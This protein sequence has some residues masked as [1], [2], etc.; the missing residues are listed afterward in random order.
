M[1][2]I[3]FETQGIN[4]RPDYPPEPVGVAIKIDDQP[5]YY[6]A[7]GHPTDNN[8]T[9]EEAQAK[10]AAVWHH[11]LLFYNAKFDVDVANVHLGLPI[12]DWMFIH[13]AMFLAFLDNPNAK[14]MGL[15]PIAERVLNLPPDEQDE[16]KSWLLAKQPVPDVKISASASSKYAF[17]RYI[18]EAPGDIV[19]KYACGDV[20]RTYQLY[21]LLMPSIIERGMQAAYDR[22]T[23]LMPILLQ[24]ERQGLRI[25]VD[26]LVKD[27]ALYSVWTF[28]LEEWIK[29]CLDSKDDLNLNSGAQLVNAM[30]VVHK[31]NTALMPVTRTGKVSTAK[32]SLLLGVTD[33]VLLDVLTYR[34]QL[35]TCLNTF[36]LPWLETARK[37]R[38]LIYTS[39]N[40]TKSG[41]L[42]AR[43]GRL[44]SNPNFMNIPKAFVPINSS[45]W[46]ELPPLPDVRS[47]II[48]FVDE[49][50]IDRDYIA[51][52]IRLLAHFENGSLL[53]A[54]QKDVNLD[55]HQHAADLVTKLTGLKITRADAKTIAFAIL[56]GAGNTKLAEQIKCTTEEAR[57]I[58]RVY[59]TA[60]PDVKKMI[61]HLKNRCDDNLPVCTWGGRQYHVEPQVL[62]DGRLRTFEYKMLNTLIQA[63]AADVTKQAII[64]FHKLKEPGWRMILNVHDQLTVSVP[65]ADVSL[66]MA[67]L[68]TAMEDV[69]MDVKML[70]DGRVGEKNWAALT[71][72]PELDKTLAKPVQ[73]ITAW[74]FSR[75]SLYMQC[76]LKFK[77]SAI[78]K[79][80]EPKSMAMLRGSEIHKMAED[81]LLGVIEEL[82][83]ELKRFEAEFAHLRAQERLHVEEN[84][85]F[86]N[87][88]S[89]AD[90]FDMLNCWARIKLDCAYYQ[91]KGVLRVIDWKTGKFRSADTDTY[92]KQLELYAL[93]AMV[94]LPGIKE[95][96]PSL[97]YLDVGITYPQESVSY[98]RMDITRLKT[99]WR[100]RVAPMMGDTEFLPTRNKYCYS[101]FYRKSNAPNGG[102]QC[103]LQN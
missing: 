69:P 89:K 55:L 75:Y 32:K 88:W 65:K 19:A 50:F 52:E 10:L 98:L 9:V 73:R 77:L 16:V 79:I 4:P 39:W 85:A 78:D 56:Y 20:D 36:M 3:D 30:K 68:R 49:V 59:L 43:T 13:D 100:K 93:A 76:P 34:T 101:C 17:G 35:N 6:Y 37:S 96:R 95:V 60:L 8:C 91:A 66:A 38:G 87:Q 99:L 48:P 31:V 71:A 92:T 23:K 28:K 67:V 46:D 41:G 24:M 47:Y 84:W 83:V 90:W 80:A 15:K 33:T 53:R 42:G 103:P 44:S 2:T 74:S 63:S 25:D 45:P 40:Q 12:P 61:T 86:D 94:M 102:G 64:N 21:Q 57:H 62:V 11:R 54:F 26:K 27:I 1:I 7:W 72:Y 14:A 70:S 22:E 51:Q 81:Y 97:A 29:L 5:A 58:K 18:C 82:P